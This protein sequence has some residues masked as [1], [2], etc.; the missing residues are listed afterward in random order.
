M[1]GIRDHDDQ[2]RIERKCRI[3]CSI[4]VVLVALGCCLLTA[5]G[6]SIAQ[7]L[8]PADLVHYDL[9]GNRFRP[10]GEIVGRVN[11]THGFD[12]MIDRFLTGLEGGD[13]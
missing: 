3:D 6:V 5:Q 1:S 2:R 12:E 10:Q 9:E 13:L 11:G 7:E 8:V 4:V